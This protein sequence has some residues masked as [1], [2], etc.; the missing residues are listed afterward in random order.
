[1]F[2]QA[3][4][5][6]S[7]CGMNR[8]RYANIIHGDVRRG[9]E[10]GA[11]NVTLAMGNWCPTSRHHGTNICCVEPL[12]AEARDTLRVVTIRIIIFQDVYWQ[13]NDIADTCVVLILHSKQPS[14]NK[15]VSKQ[16]GGLSS[17]KFNR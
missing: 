10:F 7:A 8:M 12:D 9:D 16:N 5:P 13:G 1:M 15:Q 3:W 6:V 2:A 17:T 4:T 14:S 11:A